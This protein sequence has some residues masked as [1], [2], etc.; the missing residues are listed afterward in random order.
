[1]D[2]TVESVNSALKRARFDNGVLPWFA[3]LRSLPS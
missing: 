1:L 2:S 3:L